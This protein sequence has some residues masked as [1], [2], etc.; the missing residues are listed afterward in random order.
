MWSSH[1]YRASGP[2]LQRPERPM[3]PGQHRV[4]TSVAFNTHITAYSECI[5]GHITEYS[6]MTNNALLN[7][8]FPHTHTI[9]VQSYQ[10]SSSSSSRDCVFCE[11]HC[12][13]HMTAEECVSTT[14][15]TQPSLDLK[16]PQ[17][18]R[19]WPTTA[20]SLSPAD[21][22]PVE[23][24]LHMYFWKKQREGGS[25]H[26]LLHGRQRNASGKMWKHLY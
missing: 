21:L 1:K 19:D 2:V 5:S 26:W 14:S 4:C 23:T 3:K 12:K 22:R 8:T 16:A 13:H 18:L 25:E 20:L 17:Q 6:S 9:I 15:R 7:S 24:L 11:L 10:L